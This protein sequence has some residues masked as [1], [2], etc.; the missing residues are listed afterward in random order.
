MMGQEHHPDVAPLSQRVGEPHEGEHGHQVA[1]VLVG[2]VQRGVE[3]AADDDLGNGN[4]QRDGHERSRRP[5][6]ESGERVDAVD[7]PF[8]APSP[9]RLHPDD[10]GPR[11]RA[12]G[13][14]SSVSS[15]AAGYRFTFFM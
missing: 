7:D 8:H 2:D 5:P 11:K 3:S 10:E 6:A 15:A 12:P 9:A 13:S 4:R 1:R 14:P